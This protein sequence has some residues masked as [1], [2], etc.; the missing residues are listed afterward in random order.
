MKGCHQRE[1]L[2]VLVFPY[3]DKASFARWS[4]A[5]DLQKVGGAAVTRKYA[6]SKEATGVIDNADDDAVV[7]HAF[8]ATSFVREVNDG[9]ERP[10]IIRRPVLGGS[11]DG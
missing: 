3:K 4:I 10:L 7:C 2:F 8:D 1:C 6:L 11:L 9:L 5:G